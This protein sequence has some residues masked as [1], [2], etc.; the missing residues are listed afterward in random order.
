MPCADEKVAGSRE[1]ATTSSCRVTFQKPGAPALGLLV[2][3]HR[4][5]AAQDVEGVVA[6]ALDEDVGA[7]EVDHHR[8]VAPGAGLGRAV[9]VAV[10]LIGGMQTVYP[11][12]GESNQ[13][14]V[15]SLVLE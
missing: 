12:G 11:G 3:V 6:D 4:L 8:V 1:I 2:P 5:V 10:V 15:Y 13:A 9:G 7:A 14:P